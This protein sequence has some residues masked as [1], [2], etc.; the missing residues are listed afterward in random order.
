MLFNSFVFWGFFALVLVLYRLLPHRAQ[1]WLLLVAS[2]VFYGYWDWRFLSLLFLST[3]VDYTLGRY[4]ALADDPA[5]RR[6]LLAASVVINLTFLGFFK[7]FGFFVTEFNVLLQGIGINTALPILQIVLPVGISFYT[8]QSLSYTVDIYRRHT[9]PARSLADFAL[10]VSFFPQLVAGPIERSSELLPQVLKPRVIDQSTFGEGI[11]LVL[12]GLFKKVVI[13]DNMAVLVNDVFSRPADTLTGMEVLAGVYAFAFQ[14]Y[15]DFSGYSNIAQG[16]ARMLGFRLGWNFRMPYFAKSPSDF[17]GRW[18]ISLSSWL[19]DYLYIPLG[20]NQGSA[21]RTYRNLA[22]T[23]LLGGLWHGAAWTF[24]VWGAFHG[25]ILIIYRLWPALGGA[26]VPR[27]A[28]E[29][30]VAAERATAFVRTVLMFHL[31]CFSW[32]LFRAQSMDQVGQMLGVVATD[33]RATEFSAF[34]V[35]ML[36]LF[37]APLLA[38]EWWL[39]HHNNQLRILTRGLW[40]QALV[41]LYF[42]LMLIIFPPLQPQAFIYFQF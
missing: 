24:V 9:E 37:A 23:M 32:L 12:M 8:F 20:G 39:E 27:E 19:R 13:A 38:Y 29:V 42:L 26:V 6:T 40:L 7:Y 34:A 41:F 2:Y 1:N 11:Y 14:I 35:A 33:L 21:A 30:N 25:A 16:L 28:T 22:V 5:W 31:V 18:H 17:W 15:G 36:A 4:I 3:T 10:Y